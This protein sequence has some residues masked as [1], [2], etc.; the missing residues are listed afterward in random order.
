MN[1]N[2]KLGR[3][4]IVERQWQER[5]EELENKWKDEHPGWEFEHLFQD[6]NWL[7]RQG[8]EVEEHQYWF[9]LHNDFKYQGASQHFTLIPRDKE[10]LKSEV[11][12]SEMMK[13]IFL[14]V[15]RRGYQDYILMK[16][17]EGSINYPHFHLIVY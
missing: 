1:K 7:M 10:S 3:T 4:T 11:V 6:I 9:I 13:L 5:K 15:H 16:K 12:F 14:L 17:S 2:P 8:L